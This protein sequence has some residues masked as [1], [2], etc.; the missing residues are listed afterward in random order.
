M[1]VLPVQNPDFRLESD[2][3]FILKTSE[4]NQKY[5]NSNQ[6]HAPEKPAQYLRAGESAAQFQFQ[7]FAVQTRST[8]I[9]I[10]KT[11]KRIQNKT[12]AQTSRTIRGSHEQR[13][14]NLARRTQSTA[15]ATVLLEALNWRLMSNFQ[16]FAETGMFSFGIH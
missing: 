5:S 2:G 6:S 7:R 10:K 8:Q 1:S 16:A 12:K 13:G 4:V 3:K 11:S 9:L 15:L 14:S